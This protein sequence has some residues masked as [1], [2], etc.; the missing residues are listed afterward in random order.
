MVFTRIVVPTDGTE[1]SLRGLAVAMQLAV[2]YSAE[3]MVVT[4]VSVPDWLARQNMEHGAIE[5]YVESDAQKSLEEPIALLRR[6]GVGAE[7]KVVVGPAPGKHP[8]GDRGHAAP[9][10]SS[11]VAGAGTSPRISCSAA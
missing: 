2:R 5:A 11:W 9:T 4:A 7:V 3:L 10:S 8:H 6:E 1:A